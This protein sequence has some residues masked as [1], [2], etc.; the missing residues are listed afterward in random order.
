MIAAISNRNNQEAKDTSVKT[1]GK[2]SP[3]RRLRLIVLPS[4]N[5]YGRSE[6]DFSICAVRPK[7]NPQVNCGEPVG[8]LL[9][10]AMP[11]TRN[12]YCT[13]LRRRSTPPDH[14]VRWPCHGRGQE[15]L[16]KLYRG[17]AEPGRDP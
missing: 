8:F 12:Q 9:R 7:Q 14:H 17:S 15:E 5:S 6:P 3:R 16:G 13:L 2:R 11:P 10:A 1:I 4:T